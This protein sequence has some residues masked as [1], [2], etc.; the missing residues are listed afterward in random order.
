MSQL[1][2][3]RICPDCRAAL[4]AAGTCTGCDLRLT[5]PLAAELWRTMQ[6]ADSLVERLR[7]QER[8][9]VTVGAPA[10]RTAGLPVAPP[11]PVPAPRQSGRRGLSAGSVPAVL[12][13]VGALCLLVAAVVFVA[14]AWSSLGLGAR[15]T[16]L[17]AVTGTFGALATRLTLRGLRGAAETFWLV[18]GALVTIDLVAGYAAGLLGFDHLDG[19][20]AAAV[21]GA[22][23]LGLGLGVGSWARRTEL[24]GLVAPTLLSG[25]GA[26]L[27]V[28]GEGWSA[29][30][31]AAGTTV[32]I[33]AL[34]ALAAFT[35][36]L[37]LRPTTYV[38]GGLAVLSWMILLGAGLDRA[39]Q[40]NASTWWTHLAGW[41]F[42][43]AA[44]LAAVVVLTTALPE[45]VRTLAAGA[46]ELAVVLL[47]V[48]PGAGANTEIVVL[49]GLAVALAGASVVAP[50]VWALPA[51]CY[52]GLAGIAAAGYA[53]L[54][55]I[56]AFDG[57]PTTGPARGANMEQRL[58]EAPGEPS[59]WTAIV[60][61]AVVG[62]V[63]LALT[64]WIADPAARQTAE[65]GWLVAAPTAAA[66]GIATAFLE[67]GPTVLGAVLAW[68]TVLAV[69]AALA[70]TVRGAPA[71]AVLAGAGY[72]GVIGLRLA[73][74]SHLLAAL[75][76]TALA[77]GLA[78]AY[79]RTAADPITRAVTGAA[80]LVTAG[81]A[82]THWPYLAGGRGDAAGVTL[83]VLAA[84]GG[85]LAVRVARGTDRPVLEVTAL[86]LGLGAVA[87]PVHDA[88]I[89]LV[90]SI[91]GSAVALVSVLHRDRDQVA[92]LGTVILGV[93]ALL[94]V[95]HDLALPELATAPA[96]ALLLVAGTRRMLTDDHAASLRVLGSGLTLA[97]L[98]TLLLS[99]DEPVSLRAALLGAGA[100][101][102]LAVGISRRWAAP[103]LAGSA[104]LAVLAVR[105]LGP[106]AEA[107][108]RWISLGA[109]G[110]LLLAVA[111][112]WESRRRQLEVAERYLTALR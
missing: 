33:L 101:I 4:D 112:T 55:P 18:V 11:T 36:K 109:L 56:D 49:A 104:V 68:A 66:L 44:L 62:L 9:P 84:V 8:T 24:A 14:V 27:L 107:L 69:L 103:F 29:P 108:P 28:A 21:L 88:V 105:H 35:R 78:I 97:L 54:R 86:A 45:V 12:F 7:V 81:F 40:V 23:L 70:T 95:T 25:G 41:P 102:T 76:A 79:R 63:G 6:V 64:R 10:A 91:V 16:I 26:L 22:A 80:V 67:T 47:V 58:L 82:A 77:V 99:I 43:V 39:S 3:P 30:N 65:R 50:R 2:D 52:A 100:L 72:L 75:L 83:A 32:A 71:V 85:L 38:V 15:T 93:A 37:G 19:R 59:A 87:F 17:L 90:L 1:T 46:S 31:T 61:V 13:G 111:I 92:W 48:G 74:P 5:G 34:V 96:A 73:V 51:A 57:L 42:V 94:R 60:V 110:V 98:P 53:L 20:H 89:T 106:V